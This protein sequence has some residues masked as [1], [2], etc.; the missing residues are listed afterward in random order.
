MRRRGA[1]K[2]EAFLGAL[3][4]AIVVLVILWFTSNTASIH[5]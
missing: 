5:P 2:G 1:G 4:L 3:L